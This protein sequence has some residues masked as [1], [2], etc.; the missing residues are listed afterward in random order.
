MS[1]MKKVKKYKLKTHKGAAK[2]FKMTGSG[3]IMRTRGPKSHFR[4]NR[5][6]TTKDEL[7]EMFEVKS[8]GYRQRLKRL[9]PYMKLYSTKATRPGSR[10]A[11]KRGSSK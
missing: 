9:I 1:K 4:R 5:S 7:S 11:G 3:K 10:G 8:A 6:A 2:R